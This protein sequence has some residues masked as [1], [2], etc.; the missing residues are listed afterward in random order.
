MCKKIKNDNEKKANK[1]H[2]YICNTNN[3]AVLNTQLM[4]KAKTQLNMFTSKIYNTYKLINTN[5]H[6]S[7][8]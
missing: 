3:W 5:K 8:T 1:L 4:R 7:N 2:Y 6:Y